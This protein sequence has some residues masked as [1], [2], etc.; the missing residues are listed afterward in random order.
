MG[1]NFFKIF[2][3]NDFLPH[4]ICSV[5][6]RIIHKNNYDNLLGFN[7]VNTL[8]SNDVVTLFLFHNQ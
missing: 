5:S 7:T 4:L 2:K 8:K 3:L 6:K 1:E